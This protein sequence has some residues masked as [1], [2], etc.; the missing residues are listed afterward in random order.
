MGSAQRECFKKWVCH[1]QSIQATD[2]HSGYART[3]IDHCSWFISVWVLRP[4]VRCWA[5]WMFRLGWRQDSGTPQ[6]GECPRAYGLRGEFSQ[7]ARGTLESCAPPQEWLQ[8]PSMKDPESPFSRAP[9]LLKMGKEW[10]GEP[11]AV[12]LVS[13]HPAGVPEGAVSPSTPWHA[14]MG[15]A[16]NSPAVAAL[17]R[18]LCLLQS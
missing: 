10:A 7:P 16:H 15:L 8:K 14:V 2:R 9:G 4:P 11:A 18:F 5:M 1:I 17:A 12:V 3:A 13:D 6:S